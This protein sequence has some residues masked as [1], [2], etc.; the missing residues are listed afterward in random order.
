MRTI[1]KK[2]SYRRFYHIVN[3]QLHRF[4]PFDLIEVLL[5]TED[6]SESQHAKLSEIE[7]RGQSGEELC[8]LMYSRG[9][10]FELN[11]LITGFARIIIYN[12]AEG[13]VYELKEGK[14]N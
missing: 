5:M 7:R 3:M 2:S 11:P 1:L 8:C 6:I 10:E 4:L 9:S 14:F 12:K 13:G